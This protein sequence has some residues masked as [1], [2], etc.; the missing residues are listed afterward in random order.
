MAK[1]IRESI[2]E[3]AVRKENTKFCLAFFCKHFYNA[4]LPNKLKIWRENKT[5]AL[6]IFCLFEGLW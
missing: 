1:K 4:N 6:E 3:L 2:L 5:P